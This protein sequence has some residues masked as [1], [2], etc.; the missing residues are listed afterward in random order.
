VYPPF[1]RD[2]EAEIAYNKGRQAVVRMLGKKYRLLLLPFKG[3]LTKEEMLEELF[4]NLLRFREVVIHKW[5][6]LAD[7]YIHI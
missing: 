4:F 3:Q 6:V 1:S 7:A 5:P 2:S